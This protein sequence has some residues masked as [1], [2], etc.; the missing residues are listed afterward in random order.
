M[1]FNINNE[2]S[3]DADGLQWILR[4]KNIGMYFIATYKKYLLGYLKENDIF[5]TDDVKKKFDDLP[6]TFSEYKE[7]FNPRSGKGRR[8]DS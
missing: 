5:L 8:K 4:K 1:I 6:M 7:K 3:L 2:W